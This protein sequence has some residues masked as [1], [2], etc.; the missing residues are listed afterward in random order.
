[1]NDIFENYYKNH[2]SHLES[3]IESI[4]KGK[5]VK[6][7]IIQNN[8]PINLYDKYD[9]NY[10]S[11]NNIILKGDITVT[12]FLKLLYNV[13]G[14]DWFDYQLM[15]IPHL[16]IATLKTFYKD[17]WD[18]YSV[19]IKKQYEINKVIKMVLSCA[20]RRDG[21]TTMIAA[22]FALLLLLMKGTIERQ[23]QLIIASK[24]KNSSENILNDV[25]AMLQR[26]DFDNR[27]IKIKKTA[28]MLQVI[29]YDE[30]GNIIN[31]CQVLAFSRTGVSKLIFFIFYLY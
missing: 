30:N 15:L 2:L 1:M 13:K 20:A 22:W 24:D 16:L 10:K 5:I 4:N 28:D 9:P 6:R 29:T 27:R 12:K 26:I 23:F 17:E 3:V 18:N 8:N 31:I 7:V 14:Y 19:R 11:S 25:H 21:K